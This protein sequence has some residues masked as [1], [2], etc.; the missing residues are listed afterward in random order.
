MGETTVRGIHCR[1]P[2]AK[3]RNYRQFAQHRE[4]F[5]CQSVA[6]LLFLGV[7]IGQR[8]WWRKRNDVCR[9]QSFDYFNPTFVLSVL[10]DETFDDECRQQIAVYTVYHQLTGYIFRNALP[11][12]N[13]SM[14][15]CL[16]FGFDN[17]SY[18]FPGMVDP[19][20]A[21]RGLRV[22]H[23]ILGHR[24]LPP[25][26]RHLDTVHHARFGQVS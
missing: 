15:Y 25:E 21:Q 16:P 4:P 17:Y 1:K 5:A 18:C 7:M 13:T 2:S 11:I 14:V 8:H 10:S 19:P 3:R 9:K 12:K 20:V 26:V 6:I 24:P 22:F 23:G